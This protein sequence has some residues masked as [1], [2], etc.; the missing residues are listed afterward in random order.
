MKMQVEAESAV[1][2]SL[3]TI[4]AKRQALAARRSAVKRAKGTEASGTGTADHAPLQAALVAMD[5]QTGHVRAMVGGRDFDESHFNRAVQAK[6]QPGSAFKP[7]VYAAALEAGYSPATI[8]DNLGDPIDTARG[9]WSPEDHSTAPSMTLRTALR[10][11]SNRA[12]VRLL[13]Q[14][15]IPRTVQYART[16]GVGELPSV[17]SLALGS[18]EV[19]V[20]AITAA[21]AGFANHGLVP[22]AILIRRVEDRDGVVLYESSET[23][24][25]AIS[26]TTAFLMTS[27]L[28]DVINAGTGAR[29]RQL[30]FTLPAAGKTGTTNDF[31]DAWF[32]GF[33]TKLVTG[34]WVGFDQARTILPNGFAADIAVPL[35]AKFMKVAT[36]G[37]KPEWFTPPAGV[38]TASVC[39]LTGKLATP[40]CESVEVANKDGSIDRKS[41][42]YTEYFAFG[43]EPIAYCDLH[44][45]AS[46][47]GGIAGLV[48]STDNTS[49]TPAAEPTGLPGEVV[50]AVGTT[51]TDA[52]PPKADPDGKKPLWSRLFGLARDKSKPK[53][54]GKA[55]PKKGG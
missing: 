44:N 29:A 30:G 28:A 23:P 20:Q 12:A 55:P 47:Y 33:T 10:T 54:D 39:R 46:T 14:I 42:V 53:D 34:V 11:S 40:E 37:D 26:E 31:K 51:G 8:L 15:G 6:R 45:P 7:F 19:T 21:Y 22:H 38:T 24:T 43:T 17:P 32:V 49:P 2:E 50:D 4:D 13:Q 25:R 1:A 16:M 18:G 41:M 3:K 9:A 5:P 35:W 36:Q 48:G 27:M 52:V